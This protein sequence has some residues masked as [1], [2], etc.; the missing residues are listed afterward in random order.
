[1]PVRCI[2]KRRTWSR[3]GGV[4]VVVGAGR[5]ELGGALLVGWTGDCCIMRGTGC[6]KKGYAVIV[7]FGKL[8]VGWDRC[9]WS[10]S[11]VEVVPVCIDVVGAVKV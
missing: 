3:L 7:L 9:Q 8:A 2:L 6:W 11:W 1:M 10:R 5:G 4:V